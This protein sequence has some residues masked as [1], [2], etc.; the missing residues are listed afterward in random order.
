MPVLVSIFAGLVANG[1]DTSANLDSIFGDHRRVRGALLKHKPPK[2][3]R[4][5]R[6][7]R[8]S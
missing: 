3:R 2:A 6:W 8:T 4:P 7:G 5:P 1:A